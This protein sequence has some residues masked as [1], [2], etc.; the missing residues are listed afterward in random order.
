LE[1]VDIIGAERVKYEF[2]LGLI[3]ACITDVKELQP[4]LDQENLVRMIENG[5]T[6][7]NSND[8][9]SLGMRNGMRW[10]K[11]LID[12]VEPKF[13]DG[14]T[15]IADIMLITSENTKEPVQNG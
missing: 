6:A 3:E 13:E 7:T 2:G 12:G 4:A 11:S 14:V 9:Y 15:S 8:V 10:C 1:N 5:I